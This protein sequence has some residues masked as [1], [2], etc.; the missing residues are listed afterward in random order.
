MIPKKFLTAVR[1]KT[2]R[3]ESQSDE[4]TF[5]VERRQHPRINV[6][7]PL[8]YSIVNTKEGHGGMVAD[9]SEGGLLVYLKGQVPI[10]THLKIEMLF[11]KGLELSS[12]KAIAKVVWAD[13]AARERFREFRYGLQFQSF[14]E[15][16]LDRLKVLLNEFGR[17]YEP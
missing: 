7:L 9:A 12:I 2:N 15:G 14:H 4:G 3:G 10:G 17:T 13:L 16:D 5:V 1:R 6:E 8:D 11:V